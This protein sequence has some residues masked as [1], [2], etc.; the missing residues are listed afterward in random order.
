M[1]TL[2]LLFVGF[3]LLWIFAPNPPPVHA[4]C[5]V[6]TTG[7]Y[8]EGANLRDDK[9]DTGGNKKV[10]LGGAASGGFGTN[11][12]AAPSLVEGSPG[13]FSFDLNGNAR[14][15]Q[16]TLEAG[17]DQA[18]NLVMTS[19][20]AMRITTIG[21]LTSTGTTAVNT[22]FTGPVRFMAQITNATSETKAATLDIYGN[23]TSSTT[24]G[25]KICTITLPSTATVTHLEDT[26]PVVSP[27]FM[28]YYFT[29]TVYTSASAAPLT[30]Y[31]M[32]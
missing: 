10:T 26:C 20:G 21:S 6:E 27:E 19:G 1:K 9:C 18:N 23:W 5:V 12:A 25:I 11:T 8:A 7:T 3:S 28:F 13:S 32:Q 15:T 30:L 31:G 2:R 24:G 14:V 17:E 16:G 4:S 29:S 22:L